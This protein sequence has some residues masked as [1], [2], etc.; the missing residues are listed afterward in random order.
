[1]I[2]LRLIHD[3]SRISLKSG[4]ISGEP[5]VCSPC[6]PILRRKKCNF[7]FPLGDNHNIRKPI[8]QTICQ[9]D[10]NIEVVSLGDFLV[11]PYRK[12]RLYF[13]LPS[14]QKGL[15]GHYSGHDNATY[16]PNVGQVRRIVK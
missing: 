1:M 7:R 11:N 3:S 13:G 16:T 9:P 8:A 5:E 10:V 15:L 2:F 14:N 12:C 6:E 4:M